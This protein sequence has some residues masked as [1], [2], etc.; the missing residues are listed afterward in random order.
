MAETITA[1]TAAKE[2]PKKLTIAEILAQRAA[3]EAQIKAQLEEERPA[4]LA[5]VKEQI[6]TFTFTAAELGF[7]S[8]EAIKAVIHAE[9][10]TADE[11]GFHIPTAGKKAGGESGK[12]RV[13]SKPIKNKDGSETGVW[14][15]HPPKFLETEGCYTEFKAGKSID[16]WLVN[17]ADKKAKI[18][19]LKK[20]ASRES[21]QPTK[22]QLGE[23]TEAEFKAD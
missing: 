11:L 17:P 2:A 3:F 13:M 10:F 22:E 4:A 1:K 23:I 21:K 20:L 15:A 6:E 16:A 5:S 19:F 18:N 7:A 12:T 14:L 8:L 9:G